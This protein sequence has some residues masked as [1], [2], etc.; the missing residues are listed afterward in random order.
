MVIILKFEARI[1]L[2]A[3]K[4]SAFVSKFEYTKTNDASVLCV[5]FT[6][7]CPLNTEGSAVALSK[8]TS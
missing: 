1:C 7:S 2:R 5:L 3:L 8:G 6:F 4:P